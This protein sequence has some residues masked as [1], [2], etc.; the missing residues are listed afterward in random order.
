V[1]EVQRFIPVWAMVLLGRALSRFCV[2]G[3]PKCASVTHLHTFTLPARAN[4]QRFAVTLP[5]P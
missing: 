2:H 3:N 4:V 1:I 5:A